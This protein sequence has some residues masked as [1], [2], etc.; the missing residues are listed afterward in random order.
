[1]NRPP[2]D[3][4]KEDL[5]EVLGLLGPGHFSAEEIHRRHV[6]AA[7]AHGHEPMHPV[8][9]GQVLKEYGAIRKQKW[10]GSKKR[11]PEHHP[12]YMVKGW[13]V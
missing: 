8:R 4:E 12:G 9:L 7:T 1:M 13:I 2:S 5:R 10:D 3:R 6:A 11:S